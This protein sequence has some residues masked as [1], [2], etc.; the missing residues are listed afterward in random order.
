MIRSVED[1]ND[2][3]PR[4]HTVCQQCNDLKVHLVYIKDLLEPGVWNRVKC[5]LI[6]NECSEYLS[7]THF[8]LLHDYR[9]NSKLFL[10]YFACRAEFLLFFSEYAIR[11]TVGVDLGGDAGG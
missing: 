1:M 8:S 2:C 3:F 4:H 7:H 11:F 6:I 5:R 9:V 10:T